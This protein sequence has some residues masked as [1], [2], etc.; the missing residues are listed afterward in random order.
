MENEAHKA[1]L[2]MIAAL[3]FVIFIIGMTAESKATPPLK[4]AVIDTGFSFIPFDRSG[5]KLCET[6]H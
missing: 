1:H 5:F 6:G 3:L 2:T 4:V